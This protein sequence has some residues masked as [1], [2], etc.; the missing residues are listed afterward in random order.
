MNV[1]YRYG[2]KEHLSQLEQ[3][4]LYC[5]PIQ[6]FKNIEQ[7][8]ER[9]DSHE[10]NMKIF[11]LINDPQVKISLKYDLFGITKQISLNDT[12]EICLDLPHSPSHIFCFS[13]L[14]IEVSIRSILLNSFQSDSIMVFQ[15]SFLDN[16]EQNLKNSNVEYQIK[17]VEYKE[18]NKEIL[19]DKNWVTK[20]IKYK[21]Q[22]EIRIAIWNQPTDK[23][24]IFN[25]IPKGICQ[26]FAVL[27]QSAEILI[28]PIKKKSSII[29]GFFISE[30]L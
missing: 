13:M 10:G 2:E 20:H 27:K 24:F 12:R 22:N 19:F 29:G 21:D 4:K 26:V 15:K 25:F 7:D 30:I 5:N 11:T 8:I 3:G 9:G 16:I 28:T 18:Y 14:K 1:M 6:Y 23:P 17:K